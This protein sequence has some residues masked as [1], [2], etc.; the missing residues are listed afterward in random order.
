MVKEIDIPS[1]K[2]Q[3]NTNKKCR[4]YSDASFCP[5]NFY[6]QYVLLELEEHGWPLEE[7][8]L[9]VPPGSSRLLLE[10]LHAVTV[11]LVKALLLHS[12]PVHIVMLM[13]T[14]QMLVIPVLP[15]MPPVKP[16]TASL[17]RQ[18]AVRD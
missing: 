14:V 12:L 16:R 10:M 9:H 5:K 15:V 3:E 17:D 18:L 6:F 13:S 7:V 4:K 8:V 2:K 1:H 11:Q